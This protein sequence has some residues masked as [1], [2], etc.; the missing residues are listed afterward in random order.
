MRP[1][2]PIG[3]IVSIG[4]CLSLSIG[5][6]WV[7]P[8]F[9]SAT[10]L[11]PGF[12]RFVLSGLAVGVICVVSCVGFVVTSICKNYKFVSDTCAVLTVTW[13]IVS[14][15]AGWLAIIWPI[16]HPDHL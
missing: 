16:T 9:E 13:L 12:T 5:C 10:H 3:I 1:I 15:S 11:L 6:G 14:L 2:T 8:H 4:A 7:Q